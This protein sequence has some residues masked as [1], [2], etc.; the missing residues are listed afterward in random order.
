MF[1]NAPAAHA[2]VNLSWIK[3]MALL[4]EANLLNGLISQID[5]SSEVRLLQ[6]LASQ[7]SERAM[8]L[9]ENEIIR[10]RQQQELQSHTVGAIKE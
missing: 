4:T 7:E 1:E 2:L 5:L 3:Q 8:M 9:K 10:I 6:E